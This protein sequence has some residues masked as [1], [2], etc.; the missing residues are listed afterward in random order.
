MAEA[1]DEGVV[2]YEGRLKGKRG[3]EK[4]DSEAY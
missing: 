1:V 4:F 2:L 3:Y